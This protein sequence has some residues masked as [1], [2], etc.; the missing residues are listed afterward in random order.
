MLC[1]I[2]CRFIIIIIIIKH[3]FLCVHRKL[4]QPLAATWNETSLSLSFRVRHANI[5]WGHRHLITGRE[6]TIQG[7]PK[8]WHTFCTPYNFIKFWPIFK[9]FYFLNQAKICN[10]TVKVKI[11]SHL[12][13]RYTTLWNVSVLKATTENKTTFVTTLFK[14]ASSSSKADTL[15]NCRMSQLI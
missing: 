8:I 9:L 4:I 5:E 2:N 12:V 1:L 10:N 15:N 7:G 6:N 14:S 13:C 3:W 11:S